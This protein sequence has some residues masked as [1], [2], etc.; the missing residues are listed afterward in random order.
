MVEDHLN[1]KRELL[2]LYLAMLVTRAGFGSILILF[3]LYLKVGSVG[4]GIALSTYPLTEFVSAIPVGR[5]V[6]LKGRRLIL[7]LGLLS[8]SIFTMAMALTRNVYIVTLIHALMGVSAASVTISSLTII[9]DLTVR[10]NRG[11]GMGTFDF[12]NIVG[13]AVGIA[14]ATSLL[15][16]TENDYSLSF[17]ITGILMIGATLACLIF[18]QE[19]TKTLTGQPFVL[20]PLTALDSTTKAIL[21]LWFALTSIVGVIFVLPRSLMEFGLDSSHTGIVLSM[22]AFGLGLG[23]VLFG[24]ISDKIGRG[25]TLLVGLAGMILLITSLLEAFISNPPRIFE[26]LPIIGIAT[27]MSSAIVPSALAL[28]GD[29]ARTNLR[30]SA[31]GVYSMM[32]SIGIGIGNIFGGYFSS[33]GGLRTML[34]GSVALLIISILI[35]TILL[36]R[37]GYFIQRLRLTPKS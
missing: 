11:I 1:T 13:Y 6:D 23:S 12:S 18:V 31:M 35:T 26:T 34:E 20:N 24:K 14:F 19:T 4:L 10:T 29:N 3:P 32:L 21:P 30:G 7:V 28:V 17:V 25:K 37:T 36:Y 2:V 9:T 5:Y 15:H 16:F 8:I 27:I 33:L 22:G